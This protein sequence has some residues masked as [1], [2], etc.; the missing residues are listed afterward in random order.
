LLI[1]VTVNAVAR[2]LVR[3]AARSGAASMAVA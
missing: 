1:G 3:S 2:V